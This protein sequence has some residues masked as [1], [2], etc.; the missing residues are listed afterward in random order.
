MKHRHIFLTGFMGS[1]K[2]TVGP[3][4]AEALGYPF[5]DLDDVIEQGEDRSIEE[6]FA[7]SGEPD[8]RL[9]EHSYMHDLVSR[10]ATVF[11]LGG[12]TVTVGGMIAFLKSNGILVYLR[13]DTD[14]LI[15]R[16]QGHLHRPLLR[17]ADSRALAE[18]ELHRRITALLE[19][20]ERYYIEADII[21]DT[22]GIPVPRV[23]E[24]I[25]TSIADIL[26]KETDT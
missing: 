24:K 10:D 25:L 15:P 7:T 1:G 9:I 26:K 21:V 19:Q 14:D 11:A 17:G 2:S 3:P 8:F 6:I 13:T 18:G 20:R 4:V 23:V 22:S 5:L 16:L 12:G